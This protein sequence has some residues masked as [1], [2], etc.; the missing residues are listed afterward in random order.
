M[1]RNAAHGGRG[2]VV[3]GLLL[4]LP[5]ALGCSPA[6]DTIGPTD[7]RFDRADTAGDGIILEG[8]DGTTCD[9][10]SCAEACAALG[11]PVGTCVDGACSCR[12][13]SPDADSDDDGGGG[14]DGD[15][16]AGADADPD[17]PLAC[18]PDPGD[19]CGP[20]EICG[21]GSDDNCDG[22]VDED[23]SCVGGEVQ[24]CFA[25]PPG[26][27][28]I[29]GCVDGTMV[30][31]G[32]EFGSW[33]PC[34]GSLLPEPEVCD[35]KD[36]DC[37]DCVDDL[38]E[39]R[40][41]VICPTEDHAAP[42]NWY[43][44]HC[45]DFYPE[46][47]ADCRWAVVAP[48]GSA[49]TGAE[50]PDAEDTRVYFDISGDYIITVTIVDPYGA[51]HVCTFVVHVRGQGIRVEM[52]WNETVPGDSVSDVD[53]HFHRNRPGSGWFNADDCYYANCVVNPIL[54]WV[55]YTIAWGYPDSPATACARSR[56]PNP[57]LDIDDVEGWG[58]ENVN[59]DGAHDGD[60]FRVA[61]HYYDDDTWDGPADVM[62]RIYCGGTPRVVYGPA[63]INNVSAGTGEIW[64]VA[65]IVARGPSGDDCEITSLASGS[66]YD[67]RPDSS[68][69]GF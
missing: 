32:F 68:R 52:W 14:A 69:S 44:L 55:S 59:I 41:S 29:G 63:R 50:A 17:A 26:R 48:A 51:T 36:N 8:L 24:S 34:E 5:A 9:P 54:P 31:T 45:G 42:L 43:E 18:P 1:I 35:G 65:D 11:Y 47:G 57:R 67:I 56:C 23:C 7:G 46:G 61:V 37:N 15:H 27:R 12:P 2:V 64:R 21:N 28:G 60:L 25:G 33:G 16:D 3:T 19:G 4:L 6:D 53:L 13:G 10:A 30:C 38:E 49:T 20:T 58:P 22:R 40:P 66:A 39:C 62:V